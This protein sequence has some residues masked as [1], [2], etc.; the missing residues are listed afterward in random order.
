ML[1]HIEHLFDYSERS[2]A[3]ATKMD[4]GAKVR[5]LEA[6][7]VQAAN[8][9]ARK[10]AAALPNRVRQHRENA[11]LI[12]KEL[13]AKI[14]GDWTASTVR[15]I[16]RGARKATPQQVAQLADAVQVTVA[17]LSLALPSVPVEPQTK[18]SN[19][20][21]GKLTGKALA[22]KEDVK[23]EVAAILSA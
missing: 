6:A 13:A 17:K 3:V 18:E 5:A 10:A 11:D 16:E 21:V 19:K 7:A 8:P 4:Y 22:T 9:R 23:A 12:A 14:G 2:M 15:R 1:S 20:V